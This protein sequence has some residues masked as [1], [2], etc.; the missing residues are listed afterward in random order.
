MK[1]EDIIANLKDG[2]STTIAT[3]GLIM[4]GVSY[5]KD[6]IAAA[7]DALSKMGYTL[8]PDKETWLYLG[9]AAVFIYLLL[10]HGKKSN[11]TRVVLTDKE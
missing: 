4:T 10:F 7:T 2:P 5:F 11:S 8:T 6:S 3:I 1:L 9:V